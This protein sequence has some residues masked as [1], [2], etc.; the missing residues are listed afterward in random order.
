MI[1]LILNLLRYWIN[2]INM[3]HIYFN[4]NLTKKYITIIG[5]LFSNYHIVKDGKY[6][7]IPV[8]YGGKNKLIQRY[9][10]RDISIKGVQ[11]TLPRI[12]YSFLSF[13]YD[14][15]RKLNRLNKFIST[16]SPIL[17]QSL[18]TDAQNAKV[19]FQYTPVPY[20]IGVEVSVIT[21]KNNDA[22]QIVEQII[23]KFTPDVKLKS[24]LIPENNILM[25]I[26]LC[27]EK[28]Y[29]NDNYKG[30]LTDERFIIY[31]FNFTLKCFYFREIGK[32]NLITTVLAFNGYNGELL[33]KVRPNPSDALMDSVYGFNENDENY[34]IDFTDEGG[35]EILDE[36]S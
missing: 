30:K 18:A 3:D 23:P 17:P 35:L 19:V 9:L 21:N 24:N 12:G 32:D 31:T 11:M 25:D 8:S 10:R 27:L 13:N 5:S 28:V 36:N 20:N 7:L 1:V 29:V 15:E 34:I 2:G 4:H 26:S 6:I 14:A 16:D 33:G 22:A